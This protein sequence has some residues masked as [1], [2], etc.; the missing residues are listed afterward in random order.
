MD[1]TTYSY[2]RFAKTYTKAIIKSIEYG[3]IIDGDVWSA[4][5]GWQKSSE[6]LRQSLETIEKLIEENKGE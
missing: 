1:N 6:Q 3:D 4:K 2:L 5:N